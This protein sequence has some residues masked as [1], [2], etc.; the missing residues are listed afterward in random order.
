MLPGSFPS[1]NVSG[2]S[3]TPKQEKK[4]PVRQ[5]ITVKSTPKR[6]Q[7]TSLSITSPLAL[8]LL[9]YEEPMTKDVG[10]QTNNTLFELLDYGYSLYHTDHSK[11]NN[12]GIENPGIFNT[13]PRVKKGN[14]LFK[15][16]CSRIKIEKIIFQ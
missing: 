1:Q 5:Q 2:K 16:Y 11:N 13:D 4:L 8:P 7:K 3:T 12:F 9:N 14:M 6:T 15:H 10:T